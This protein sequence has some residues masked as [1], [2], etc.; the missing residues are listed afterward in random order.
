MCVCTPFSPGVPLGNILLL[1]CLYI[2]GTGCSCRAM[3]NCGMSMCCNH[4]CISVLIRK[5][6]GEDVPSQK[7]TLYPRWGSNPR[8]WVY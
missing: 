8:P 6:I 4:R 7:Y 1:I 3:C 2:W 5:Q